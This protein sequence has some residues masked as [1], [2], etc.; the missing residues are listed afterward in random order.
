[1]GAFY[2]RQTQRIEL[3]QKMIDLG[4]ALEIASGHYGLVDNP[5][6]CVTKDQTDD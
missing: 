6:V 4:M 2:D 5:K 1:M 3:E